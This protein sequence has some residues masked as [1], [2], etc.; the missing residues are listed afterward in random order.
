M[1]SEEEAPKSSIKAILM[2]PGCSDEEKEDVHQR[3]WE[4][5]ETTRA[6]GEQP[7]SVGVWESAGKGAAQLVPRLA[8]DAWS[9]REVSSRFVRKKN[10]EEIVASWGGV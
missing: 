6:A 10:T 5:K 1:D 9:N 7:G 4:A 3:K 8:M 2:K